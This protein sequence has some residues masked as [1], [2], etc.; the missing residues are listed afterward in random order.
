MNGHTLYGPLL[1]KNLTQIKDLAVF[2]G[3]SA[4]DLRSFL[5]QCRCTSVAAKTTIMTEGCKQGEVYI[6]VRGT[7]KV[8]VDELNG[9]QVILAIC[10]PGEAFGDISAIDGL[11]HSATITTLEPCQFLVLSAASFCRQVQSIAPLSYNLLKVQ[12]ARVR[13][14]STHAQA[15]SSLCGLGRLSYLLLT[16]AQQY[17]VL[18]AN[19]TIDLPLQLTQTDLAA[20]T[21]LTRVSVNK[22]LA[23]YQ[24]QHCIALDRHH[25]TILDKKALAWYCQ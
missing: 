3:L 6:L 22:A 13:R 25:I 10:G 12:V 18:Q 7:V 14:L 9:Q 20:L 1:S 21:G 5:C 11:P 15:L 23:C 17:G 4:E 24:R 2:Q 19:G 16:L 8:S